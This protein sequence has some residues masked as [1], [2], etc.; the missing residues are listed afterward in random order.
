VLLELAGVSKRF[1]SV[2]VADGP[3]TGPRA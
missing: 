2:V 1:G 3:V